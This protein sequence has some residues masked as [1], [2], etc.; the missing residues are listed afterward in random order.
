MEIIG[1]DLAKKS[2]GLSD[3]AKFGEKA[4]FWTWMSLFRGA[5]GWARANHT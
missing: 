3:K 1:E 5:H 4:E 2:Q